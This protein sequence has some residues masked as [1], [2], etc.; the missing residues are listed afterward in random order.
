MAM[1]PPTSPTTV[2]GGFSLGINTGRE[3]RQWVLLWFIRGAQSPA[4]DE[5]LASVRAL[6]G[7][8][9]LGWMAPVV[10]TVGGE[11]RPST[12][13]DSASWASPWIT[14]I[15]RRSRSAN[16]WA[17]RTPSQQRFTTYSNT[18]H[19]DTSLNSCHTVTKIKALQKGSEQQTGLISNGNTDKGDFVQT[20][21]DEPTFWQKLATWQQSQRFGSRGSEGEETQN[22]G[23]SYIR[24]STQ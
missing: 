13:S 11:C 6:H 16:D 15:P 21:G 4:Y 9:M 14:A 5:F 2:M 23:Q 3:H 17:L 7:I 12:W 24:L 19:T 10:L 22:W 18:R 8:S 20:R 1:R